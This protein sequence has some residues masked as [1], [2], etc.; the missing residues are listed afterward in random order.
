MVKNKQQ[1]VCCNN[2]FLSCLLPSWPLS[3]MQVKG[4]GNFHRQ[5]LA[6]E[7]VGTTLDI[8]CRKNNVKPYHFKGQF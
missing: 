6:K 1:F 8:L 5:I 3:N 7:R 4:F 2:G